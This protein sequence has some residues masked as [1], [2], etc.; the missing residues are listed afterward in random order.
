[1]TTKTYPTIIA[2]TGLAGAG[3]DSVADIL[4]AHAGFVKL[5]FADAL[6]RE[7][8]LAYNLVSMHPL[9]TDRAT[10]EVPTQRLSLSECTDG[11]F[12]GGI[13]MAAARLGAPVTVDYEWLN[14]PRSPRQILQWWG[15][16]YRRGQRADYWLR[17]MADA[18][19][20]HIQ[21]EGRRRFIITDCRFE[22]EA[23][24]I[25]QMG[26]VVWQ[27]VRGDLQS[28]E[29]GHAS[30]TDGSKLQP[31]VVIDNS[32]TL[33]S[34]REGVLGEWWAMDAQIDLVRVEIAA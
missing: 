29:G 7:V 33:H 3:K 15:T 25:R 19:R 12:I 20:G 6:R 24:Q 16:E 9:T 11:A 31:S 1:M 34:L 10:K 14:R 4:V 26:G 17:K 5:A 32:S 22:N 30:Q 18:I 8:E 23:S 27:V 2:L 13:V 28:V 21:I